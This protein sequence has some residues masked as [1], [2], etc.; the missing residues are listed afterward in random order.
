MAA[1]RDATSGDFRDA[2]L[3]ETDTEFASFAADAEFAAMVSQIK[4]RG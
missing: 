1:V 4:G 3:F 2:A